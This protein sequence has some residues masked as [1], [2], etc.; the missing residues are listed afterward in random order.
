MMPEINYLGMENRAI[1]GIVALV[2]AH[3]AIIASYRNIR[4]AMKMAPIGHFLIS[5]AM[6][7]TN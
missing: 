5:F 4:R 6:A 1:S 2:V 3:A 7:K